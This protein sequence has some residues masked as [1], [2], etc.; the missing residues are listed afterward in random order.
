MDIAL[1]LSYLPREGLSAPPLGQR[2]F[3]S[4]SRSIMGEQ[5]FALRVSIFNSV[6]FV[7]QII[8]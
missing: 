6:V 3:N 8:I 1:E 7:L 4:Y 2:N 5:S